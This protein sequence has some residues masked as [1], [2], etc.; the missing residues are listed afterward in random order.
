[1]RLRHYCESLL[2]VI[3]SSFLPAR[4]VADNTTL[5]VLDVAENKLDATAIGQLQQAPG[6]RVL[7]LFNNKCVGLARGLGLC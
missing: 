1:M 2:N 5:R 3:G 6:L 7:R 4:V